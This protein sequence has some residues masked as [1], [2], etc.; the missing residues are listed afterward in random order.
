MN[1][2]RTLNRFGFKVSSL[3][4]ATAFTL[5]EIL[6]TV[7]I[8]LVLGIILLTTSGTLTQ[9]HSSNLQSIAA[10]VASKE[11][12]R[13]RDIDYASLPTS[14]P[15]SDSDLSKLPTGAATRTITNYQSSTVI[16]QV[17]VTVTW[18]I[19]GANRQVSMDTLIYQNG[20]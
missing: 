5:V 1:K 3:K 6:I 15:V 18:E 12:E 11:I 17:S 13:L 7:F 2:P 20:I 19:N 10:K 9:R 16:K 14:G 8:I 4:F